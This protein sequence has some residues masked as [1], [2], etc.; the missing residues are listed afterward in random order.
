MK[1]KAGREDEGASCQVGPGA[2]SSGPRTEP[3]PRPLGRMKTTR[4]T[5]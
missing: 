2:E 3:K 4:A 1:W 5:G